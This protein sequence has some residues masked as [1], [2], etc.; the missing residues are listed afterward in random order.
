MKGIFSP[1]DNVREPPV[2]PTGEDVREPPLPSNHGSKDELPSEEEKI[3]RED[4]GG[5]APRRS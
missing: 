4:G 3:D 1:V 5:R 2:P